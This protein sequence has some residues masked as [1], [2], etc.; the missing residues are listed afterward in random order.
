MREYLLY[1]LGNNTYAMPI[2]HVESIERMVPI[3]PIP[4]QNSIQQGVA[5]IR[6]QMLKVWDTAKLMNVPAEYEDS[7]MLVLVEGGNAYR[8]TQ[9]KDIVRVEDIEIQRALETEVWVSSG[10]AVPV[11]DLSKKT[12][13]V[14]NA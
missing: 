11:Y 1:T 14:L 2:A 8:V 7:D 10:K 13:L 9:A 6:D 12:Q 4:L 5:V 3:T